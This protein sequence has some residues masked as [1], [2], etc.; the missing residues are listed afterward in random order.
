MK[1]RLNSLSHM[2]ACDDQRSRRSLKE[3][4]YEL[5]ESSE[6]EGAAS[7]RRSN[8]EETDS[9]RSKYYGIS[10]EKRIP[11]DCS[12]S[13]RSASCSFMCTT[14]CLKDHR[15]MSWSTQ[16]GYRCILLSLLFCSALPTSSSDSLP[17]LPTIATLLTRDPPL[18][19]PCPDAFGATTL[20][21]KQPKQAREPPVAVMARAIP[22]DLILQHRGF[23]SI[24]AI[25][26]KKM[27]FQATNPHARASK[28]SLLL[29][30]NEMDGLEPNAVLRGSTPFDELSA[31]RVGRIG[32][33][34][35]SMSEE[36]F[37]H[38]LEDADATLDFAPILK[39]K[40]REWSANAAAVAVATAAA[41]MDELKQVGKSTLDEASHALEQSSQLEFECAWRC[42]PHPLKVARGGEDVHMIC[43]SV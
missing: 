24:D 25:K 18:R 3:D 4:E 16:N 35:W 22:D 9:N 42:I 28:E 30:E 10:N 33:A 27:G 2:S 26:G 38:R 14:R 5:K 7:H 11:F 34:D 15:A 31:S 40:D 13:A 12:R 39:S 20:A 36:E 19:R 32:S 17:K 21:Y 29:V 8:F 37:Q 41:N 43:R 23:D 6:N 1:R